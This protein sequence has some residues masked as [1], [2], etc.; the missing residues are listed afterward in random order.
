VAVI[1]GRFRVLKVRST[2]AD[3]AA[4]V[5]AGLATLGGTP[6]LHYGSTIAT[7]AL[8]ERRGARVVLL[9]TLGFEDVIEIGRQTRPALYA[10]EPRRPPALVPRA[11]R[12]G[13]RERVLAD[14]TIE[15]AL[16][17]RDAMRAAAAVRRRR[18][19]AVA[20]CL[21]HS[22]ARGEHER[23]L[24]RALAGTGVH[25][26]LSH[27]LLPEYREYER[28]AIT[29]VN[30]YVAPLMTR[31]LRALAVAVPNGLRVMQSSGGLVAAATAAR[32]PVRTIL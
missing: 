5:R 14:G 16:S 30:A 18:A 17:A 12:I 32:E 4:A 29:V 20:V 21:L 10:L 24:G 8:L 9:T 11:L 27:R 28:V 6:R 25:V 1:A 3:P 15:R 26:T 2:P 19:T 31:H 22:Y 7:N 23:R 13:V